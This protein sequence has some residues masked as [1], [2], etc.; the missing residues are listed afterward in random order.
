M[1]GLSLEE[2]VLLEDPS[3]QTF[4]GGLR[5]L[6]NQELFPATRDLLQ[7]SEETNGHPH[8]KRV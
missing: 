6:Q 3:A 2:R 7:F 1:E 4:G 8:G 5:S